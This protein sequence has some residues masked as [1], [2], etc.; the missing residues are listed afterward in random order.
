[1]DICIYMSFVDL[2]VCVGGD[3]GSVCVLSDW[4]SC[5]CGGRFYSGGEADSDSFC[6]G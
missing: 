6:G 1:M 4:R 3:V 2:F 5:G